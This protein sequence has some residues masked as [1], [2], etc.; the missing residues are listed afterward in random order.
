MPSTSVAIARSPLL[1]LA[2]ALLATATAQDPIK[3][4]KNKRAETRLLAI[5]A[6]SKSDRPDAGKQIAT[7]LDDP[8]WEVAERAAV[9]LATKGSK[10]EL[11]DLIDLALDG[12]VTRLRR[13]AAAAIA[14][15]DAEEGAKQILRKAKPKNQAAA[16]ESLARIAP[17]KSGIVADE[18][19][20]KLTTDA[21][22]KLREAAAMAW[23]E[24]ADDRA[25]ALRT[26]LA[27]QF[28]AVRCVALDGVIV[29]PRADDL[30][31]LTEILSGARQNDVVER[32]AERAFAAVLRT[33]DATAAKAALSKLDTGGLAGARRARIA[34]ELIRREP[35]HLEPATILELLTQVFDG[36]NEEGRA[37]AARA[38]AFVGEEAAQKLAIDRLATDGSPR[39]RRQLLE[40][41]TALADVKKPEHA[42]VLTK[43]LESD[44]SVDVRRAAAVALGKPGV[45]SAQSALASAAVDADWTLAVCALV[46]LGRTGHDDAL[47][48]LLAQLESPE[49]TRRGA[50]VV[51]LMHFNR[52]AVVEP[53]IARLT[54]PSPIVAR[55]AHQ[56]LM[57]IGWRED[58]TAEPKAWTD[59]WRAEGKKH[60]FRDRR[61]S[62]DRQRK[63]GYEVPD[64]EIY[65]GLDVMVFVSRGDHIEQLLDRLKITHRQTQA[66]YVTQA[67]VH[68]EGIFV[69]NCT[70]EI[71]GADVDP[72][73]WFVLTG[74][75]FF[76]SCWA[77]SQSIEKFAP[78]VLKQ[79]V[80]QSHEVL[81][82]VRARPAE[83]DSP[84][85]NGVFGE[86]VVPIYHL[87]G[88]HLIEVVDPE[89]AEVLIDSPDCAE[90]HGNGNLAAWF[91][92]G[93]GVVLDSVNHFD[94]QGLEVAAG[95][96][97]E[98]DRQAYAVD[99]MGL[100][101]GKLREIVKESFWATS[102]RA[103]KNVPD[104]SA[105]RFITNF[106]RTKRIGDS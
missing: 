85:L 67:G 71:E 87:E 23:L 75:S 86:G 72:L 2:L 26:L 18:K 91:K 27:S 3:D 104:L 38:L 37:A 59:W 10:S 76:G 77:L 57:V 88:A 73:K 102:P 20:H 83:P 78:G 92:L 16:L 7:V 69:C 106:V 60:I 74:G 51:G 5:E 35:R 58:L 90:R 36:G 94:L 41:F 54:D 105:F 93:H 97:T 19:I 31:P 46:S 29:A 53:L 21:T 95:L 56:A 50:A 79:F 55:A 4:L 32:R 1:F 82:D 9:A 17:G 68:P 84:Y 61:E 62:L 8:D 63:Y 101:Y 22:A 12:P 6:L 66:N 24:I 43:A 44:G 47:G 81:D 40:S 100:T 98:R 45:K 39:V 11:K 15:I 52:A 28:L 80:T 89:R 64:S 30:A 99:H 65:R 49:W 34:A 103:A 25:K 13:E 14:A 33:M 70:G 96:K 42:L 48:V